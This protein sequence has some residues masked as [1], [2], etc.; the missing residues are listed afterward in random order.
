M[1]A[2]KAMALTFPVLE[3]CL[4]LAILNI[5]RK[6][7][8]HLKRSHLISHT[9]LGIFGVG[10]S[11]DNLCMFNSVVAYNLCLRVFLGKSLERRLL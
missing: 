2:N 9:G 7:R 4:K 8:E 6:Q 1:D 11:N 3:T 5:T 10:H